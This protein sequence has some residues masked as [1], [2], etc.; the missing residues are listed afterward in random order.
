MMVDSQIVVDRH[1]CLSGC[2]SRHPS[3]CLSGVGCQGF[4]LVDTRKEC[5]WE[6]EQRQGSILKLINMLGSLEGLPS[7][8]LY[9]GASANITK[10]IGKVTMKINLEKGKVKHYEKEKHQNTWPN[11]VRVVQ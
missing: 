1:R 11:W 7:L 3:R 2:L 4:R 5:F 6:E 10:Y 9:T 8:S